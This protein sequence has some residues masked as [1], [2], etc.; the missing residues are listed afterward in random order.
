M[1]ACGIWAHLFPYCIRNISYTESIDSFRIK[2]FFLV[3]YLLP[4]PFCCY[5]CCFLSGLLCHFLICFYFFYLLYLYRRLSSLSVIFYWTWA[6]HT[7]TKW[8]HN[9]QRNNQWQQWQQQYQSNKCLTMINLLKLKFQSFFYYFE[10]EC[11]VYNIYIDER[12]VWLSF[13]YIQIQIRNQFIVIFLFILGWFERRFLLLLL[14]VLR[15]LLVVVVYFRALL[16]RICSTHV[17]NHQISSFQRFSSSIFGILLSFHNTFHFHVFS[18]SS[19]FF[20]LFP[21]SFSFLLFLFLSYLRHAKPSFLPW[22]KIL[23]SDWIKRMQTTRAHDNTKASNLGTY[24][25]MT[26]NGKWFFLLRF[27]KCFFFLFCFLVNF[28]SYV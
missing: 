24:T 3:L 25:W 6:E 18:S 8:K 2:F 11:V 19:Q 17:S 23:S 27:F 22:Y 16:I 1:S 26:A 20:F 21:S 14:A 12:W 13:V 15:L 28:Y 5:R 4:T 7:H 9:N 10:C